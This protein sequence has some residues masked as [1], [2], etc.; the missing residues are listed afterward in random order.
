MTT[1]Q[2][3]CGNLSK[4]LVVAKPG[5]EPGTQGFFSP[6]LYQLSYLAKNVKL[7]TRQKKVSLNLSLKSLSMLQIV[8]KAFCI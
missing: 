1:F 6:L 2:I 5:I 8:Q 3:I 7:Y 4:E